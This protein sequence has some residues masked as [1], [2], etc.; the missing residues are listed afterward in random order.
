[1]PAGIHLLHSFIPYMPATPP[2]HPTLPL[3][4]LQRREALGL[5]PS[6]GDPDLEGLDEEAALAA[7]EQ[8]EEPEELRQARE[9]LAVFTAAR[10]EEE[11][12]PGEG[13]GEEVDAWQ[14][15]GQSGSW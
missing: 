14:A 8:E 3:T 4:S 7:L 15:G 10:Q 9:R 5:D 1:M 6:G 11:A 13:M 2:S 12:L